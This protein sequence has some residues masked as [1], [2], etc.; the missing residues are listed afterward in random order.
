MDNYEIDNWSTVKLGYSELGHNEQIGHFT[1]QINPEITK[2][3]YNEQF[4]SVPSCSL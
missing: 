3:G 4:Q 2:L 1:T